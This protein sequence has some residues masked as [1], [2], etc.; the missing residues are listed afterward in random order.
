M[1]FLAQVIIT[2]ILLR[3]FFK[4]IFPKILEYN[5]TE[6]ERNPKWFISRLPYYG[7]HDIDFVLAQSKY[8]TLPRFRL[9]KNNKLEFWIPYDTSVSE[10]ESIGRLALIG[11]IK[12]RYGLLYADKSLVWLSTLCYMLDGKDANIELK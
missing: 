7:F 12:C 6:V 2:T 3:L 5:M 10:I 8:G 9:G 11:K 4:H 1:M